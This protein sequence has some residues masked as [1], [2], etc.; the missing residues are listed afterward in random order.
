MLTFGKTRC[1][2]LDNTLPVAIFHVR[3][4]DRP[5][6]AEHQTIRTESLQR[7]FKIGRKIDL[8]DFRDKSRELAIDVFPLGKLANKSLPRREVARLAEMVKNKPCV[9]GQRIHELQ[10][11]RQVAFE[12]EDVVGETFCEQRPDTADEIWPQDESV[13][14]LVL[15]HM[16]KAYKFVYLAQRRRGAEVCVR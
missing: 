16:A 13:I 12:D 2:Q 14:R 15:H 8:A 3:R 7:R 6:A 11:I 1:E 9:S 10:D 5:I 4:D